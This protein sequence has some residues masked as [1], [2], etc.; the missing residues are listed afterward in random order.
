MRPQCGTWF[1]LDGG[2]P[3]QESFELVRAACEATGKVITVHA[4]TGGTF[5]DFWM[6]A[7]EP[8]LEEVVGGLASQ[9][10]DVVVTAPPAEPSPMKF[11]V[12]ALPFAAMMHRLDPP[13]ATESMA[14]PYVARRW[15]VPADAKR[16]LFQRAA[17]WCIREGEYGGVG[18]LGLIAATRADVPEILGAILTDTDPASFAYLNG[19][20]PEGSLDREVT[21]GR[22]G[23]SAWGGMLGESNQLSRATQLRE[24]LVEFAS[25][26]EIGWVAL[27]HANGFG[28]YMSWGGNWGETPQVWS[29]HA[30]D[31][32]GIMLLTDSHL[33]RTHD[34]SDWVV[35][36]ITTDR[37]LVQSKDLAAWFPTT[38]DAEYPQN[39]D[40]RVDPS[41]KAKA[42]QDFGDLI[43][44]EEHLHHY[45]RAANGR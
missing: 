15:N 8:V 26:I 24:L 9:G 36:P 21:F 7:W 33:A 18:E 25:D 12:E 41:I 29:T 40:L 31:V 35:E 16:R 27:Q 2:L 1:V 45:W 28:G 44:T 4:I 23:N 10:H 34:L 43:L 3:K 22:W 6:R 14:H 42:R 38:P 13:M 37:F 17:Q 19:Y 30:P 20:T 39:D 32:A 11:E 5:V